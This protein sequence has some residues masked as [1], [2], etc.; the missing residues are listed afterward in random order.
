MIGV[1]NRGRGARPEL[2]RV[3][4]ARAAA[5]PVICVGDAVGSAVLA[6]RVGSPSLSVLLHSADERVQF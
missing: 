1:Q 5:V 4:H 6:V 3:L 2:Q